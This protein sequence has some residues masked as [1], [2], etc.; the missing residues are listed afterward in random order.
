[1]LETFQPV[2]QVEQ[3][4]SQIVLQPREYFALT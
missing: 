2:D 3:A 4:V 1:M